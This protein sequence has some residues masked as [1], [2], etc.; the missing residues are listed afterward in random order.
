MEL[1]RFKLE[2]DLE[3]FADKLSDR[4]NLHFKHREVSFNRLQHTLKPYGVELLLFGSCANGL[5]LERSDVDVALSA[6][7]LNFF[8]YGSIKE[9]TAFALENIH[10]LLSTKK[11]ISSL[12][13]ILTAAIPVL[14]LVQ[15]I[16]ELRK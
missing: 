4:A 9:R 1:A 7:V 11:W 6:S 15:T 13:P 8:P 5:A 14:K 12:K 10:N 2:S 3:E 16:A